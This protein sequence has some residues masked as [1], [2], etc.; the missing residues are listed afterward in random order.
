MGEKNRTRFQKQSCP[1]AFT[2][3]PPVA[4][5]RRSATAEMMMVAHVR[6]FCVAACAAMAAAELSALEQIRR[7][8]HWYGVYVCMVHCLKTTELKV[9]LHACEKA[10]TDVGRCLHHILV[11]S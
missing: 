6:V 1:A 4:E 5:V 3:P 8:Y 7:N 9:R 10:G 2:S 11:G